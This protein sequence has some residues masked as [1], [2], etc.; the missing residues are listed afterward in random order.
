MLY[1]IEKNKIQSQVQ[2]LTCR[3]YDKKL[4]KCNG[5]NICCFEYDNATKT[6]I[7]GVT[8]LPLKMK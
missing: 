3:H 5:L 4:K 8:K 1:N 7:D 6:I 2:C